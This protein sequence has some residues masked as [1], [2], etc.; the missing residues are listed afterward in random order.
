[1]SEIERVI[2]EIKST[3]YD[4]QAFAFCLL[5]AELRR[6]NNYLEAEK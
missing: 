1:M 2:D 5:I 6:L 4:A 3:K